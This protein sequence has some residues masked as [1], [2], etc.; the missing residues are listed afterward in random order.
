MKKEHQILHI[1][2]L[3]GRNEIGILPGTV[4]ADPAGSY[5]GI[6]EEPFETPVQDADDL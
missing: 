1:P 6:P 4:V 5:T 2:H 3:S